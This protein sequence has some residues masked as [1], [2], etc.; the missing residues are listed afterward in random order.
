MGRAGM[1]EDGTGCMGKGGQ[2]DAFLGLGSR[3]S[4]RRLLPVFLVPPVP[5]TLTVHCSVDYEYTRLIQAK[6]KHCACI[7][8]VDG[9]DLLVTL[10][11]PIPESPDLLRQSLLCHTPGSMNLDNSLCND[12]TWHV[13]MR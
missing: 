8:L 10:P 12:A 4:L 1:K 7:A 11:R 9:P 13:E 3:A 2:R 5:L 6:N